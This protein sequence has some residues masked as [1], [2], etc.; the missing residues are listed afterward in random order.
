MSTMPAELETKNTERKHDIIN[1]LIL[2]GVA[3]GLGVYLV[4]TTVVISKD[5]VG[6]IERAR[7]FQTDPS[8]NLKTHH[9]GYPLLIFTAHKLSRLFTNDSSVFTWTYSAQGVSLFFQ[10]LALIP[11][12][13]T[14]KLLVGSRES[15]YAIL[16]LVALPNPAKMGCEVT[17]E[18]PYMFFLAAGFLFLLWGARRCAPWPFGLA[19]LSSGLGYWVRP[20]CGQIVVFGLAWLMLSILQPA[21]GKITR[22]K[23]FAALSLLL[24]GF[25]FP[26]LPYTKYTG[27]LIS[28]N[29]ERVIRL[30]SHGAATDNAD[31]S[32]DET[33][34]TN[35][36]TAGLVWRSVQEA[37]GEVFK[38][39]GENTMWFF[40]PFLLT[41]F[42][43]RMRY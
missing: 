35:H 16:I 21:V 41:G 23:S 10:L 12:Y 3:L 11:L 30:L 38:T 2:I 28:P 25:A 36:Y 9:P 4:A 43:Y 15:F 22:W 13:F 29:A 19:G 24:I 5:G 17:R 33:G 6:Y 20:E 1:M 37:L 26:A 27:N 31:L 8:G 39:T 34:A 18:W 7:Q 42:F 32:G 40:L 14:G